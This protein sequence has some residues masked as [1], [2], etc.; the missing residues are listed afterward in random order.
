VIKRILRLLFTVAVVA[1]VVFLAAQAFQARQ[2]EQQAQQAAE[3][4]DETT[5]QVGT[6]R[7]TVGAT[8]VIIPARE[9]ALAFEVPGIVQEVLVSEGDTVREGDALARLDTTDLETAIENARVAL[10]LQLIAYDALIA[11]AREE[12]IAV[13]QAAVTAAQAAVNSAYA[14]AP[15]DEQIEMARLQTEMARNQ[16]WQAQLQRDLSLNQAQT[17]I[18]ISS[19]IPDGANVS[20]ETIDQVNSALSGVLPQQSVPPSNSAA[21]LNQAEY[22]VQIADASYAAAQGRG[23]NLGSVASANAALV[24][25]QVQL[26]RL[27]NGASD[28]DLRLAEIAVQQADLAVAQAEAAL[29]RAVIT[30]PFDGMIVQVNLTVGEPPSPDNPALLL[31]DAS[32]YYVDLA[33]DETDVVDVEIGQQVDLHLDALPDAEIKGQV[34]RVALTPSV[35]AQLVTYPVRVTLAATDALIRIGMSVTATIVVDEV[36]D[37][38][39]LPNRFLRIDRATQQAYVTVERATGQFEEVPV[40]LGLR[41]ETESQ[42]VEGVEAGQRVVLLPRGTF[43]PFGGP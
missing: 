36:P 25:A 19:L 16:L 5:V 12:D 11:P 28:T 21:G 41:N 27:L 31:V 20:Q 33:I 38:L 23:A 39:I 26:D 9:V 17:G 1:G 30:A 35:A 6:L 43:D 14:S 15:S 3:I 34:T 8:G 2:E 18:D 10:D 42:I 24:A 7:V 37:T 29:N 13:A 22:S 32:R 4:L 40:Q